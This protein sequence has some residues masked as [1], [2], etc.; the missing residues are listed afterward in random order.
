MFGP[1]KSKKI[2]MTYFD[3]NFPLF[4]NIPPSKI[5]KQIKDFNPD[6]LS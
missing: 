2:F 1:S 5:F 4:K 6:K 3:H